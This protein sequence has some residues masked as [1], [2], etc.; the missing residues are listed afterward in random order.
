VCLEE[1]QRDRSLWGR[2]HAW[3]LRRH[4]SDHNPGV[5]PG[6]SSEREFTASL[7]LPVTLYSLTMLREVTRSNTTAVL[8]AVED[9]E[10]VDAP[11]RNAG[12]N[13]AG[14][15]ALAGGEER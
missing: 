15:L 7:F 14:F 5:R 2:S 11:V 8:T 6:K 12:R 13:I 1:E 4:R 10:P 9:R 3:T